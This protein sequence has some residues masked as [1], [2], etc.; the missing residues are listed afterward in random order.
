M[1]YIAYTFSNPH[2]EALKDMFAEL[3]GNIGFDSFMDEDDGFEK[4]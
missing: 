3:L 4:V 1:N 2:N